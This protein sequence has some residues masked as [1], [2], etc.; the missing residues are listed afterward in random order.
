MRQGLGLRDFINKL[1]LTNSG[2]V[3]NLILR[4]LDCFHLL[5]ALQDVSPGMKAGSSPLSGP[6]S[7]ITMSLAARIRGHHHLKSSSCNVVTWQEGFAL[8]EECH[9]LQ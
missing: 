5:A 3:E 4:L 6:A 8:Q 1:P 2:T 9:I 7:L